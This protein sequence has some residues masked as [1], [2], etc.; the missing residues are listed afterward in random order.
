MAMLGWRADSALQHLMGKS[1]VSELQKR[2]EDGRG[3]SSV[4]DPVLAGELG[5][6]ST[7]TNQGARGCTCTCSTTPAQPRVSLS[8]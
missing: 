8:L 5:S 6:K 7:Q 2:S 1:G 3:I 4:M